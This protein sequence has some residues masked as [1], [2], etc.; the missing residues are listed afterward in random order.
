MKYQLLTALP[1]VAALALGACGNP[2]RVQPSSNSTDETVT[3]APAISVAPASCL[4]TGAEAFEVLTESAAASPISK[5]DT[6]ARG[7]VATA[8][9]CQSTLNEDQASALSA[10]IGRIESFATSRN[11]TEL[12]LAAVEGYRVL[13]SAQ[14]RTATDIPL[15]VALLDYA[16]FR[17]Q[18][19]AASTPPLWDD[20]RQAVQVAEQQ[21]RSVAPRITDSALKAQ[22]SSDLAALRVAVDRSD[23]AAARTAAVN[24]LAHVDLLESHFSDRA[25]R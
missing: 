6:D 21:W 14:V 1:L 23:V 4:A 24:E 2:A 7:A 25:S 10:S 5:L 19:G 9:A 22:F 16:G 18:A 15:E 17:Y 13:V 12:A 11:R 8:R 20:M 3:S